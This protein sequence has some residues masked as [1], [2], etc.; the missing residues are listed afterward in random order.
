MA[1]RST[2]RRFLARE[3]S[4]LL[5][6]WPCQLGTARFDA[7]PR[8]EPVALRDATAVSV[9]HGVQL[10]ARV[11]RDAE[12]HG[13]LLAARGVHANVGALADPRRVVLDQPDRGEP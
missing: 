5:E 10:A 8:G 9:Q 1:A 2:P 3:P 4:R 7:R 13:A 6:R 11:E 12:L